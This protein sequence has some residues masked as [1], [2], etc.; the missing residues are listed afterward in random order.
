M[1]HLFTGCAI[2]ALCAGSVYAGG[3]DRS[4]QGIGVIFNETGA[5]GNFMQLGFGSI[6][7]EAG[8][9]D[10]DNPLSDYKQLGLAY[11]RAL[12]DDLSLS[13]I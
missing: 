8:A 6:N 2:A 9:T 4:G 12:T 3:I 1:R 13:L 7:P 10:V 11:K 5:T